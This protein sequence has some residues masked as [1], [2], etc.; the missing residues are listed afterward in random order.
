M[1][2]RTL[3]VAAK[4][5]AGLFAYLV[6]SAGAS[7]AYVFLMLFWAQDGI[8][9]GTKIEIRFLMMPVFAIC[10][11]W[12]AL[13]ASALAKPA[14]FGNTG[15]ILKHLGCSLLLGL[16]SCVLPARIEFMPLPEFESTI[17]VSAFIFA[18]FGFSILCFLSAVAVWVRLAFGK[19]HA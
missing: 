2:Q 17:G 9:R 4:W 3:I 14:S 8:S 18:G 11:L 6:L 5:L 1:H 16:I 13:Y 19:Q 7:R 10:I 15:R 12:G